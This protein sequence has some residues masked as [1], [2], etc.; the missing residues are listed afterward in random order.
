MLLL[1]FDRTI[2]LDTFSIVVFAQEISFDVFVK[3]GVHKTVARN[4]GQITR[5]ELPH[6]KLTPLISAQEYYSAF[7][8]KCLTVRFGYL[9]FWIEIQFLTVNFSVPERQWRT[10]QPR[11]RS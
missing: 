3:A 1:I 10:P 4:L 11:D 9:F 5:A 6:L 7:N 2:A 8:I